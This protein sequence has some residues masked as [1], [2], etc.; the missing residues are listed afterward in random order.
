MAKGNRKAR[1]VGEVR[2]NI[3]SLLLKRPIVSEWVGE[4]IVEYVLENSPAVKNYV[5][6]I[7]E[8]TGIPEEAVKRSEAV[9]KYIKSLL[10]I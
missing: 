1:V 7:A 9:R 3:V 4:A 10:G 6:R 5:K 2:S 8:F